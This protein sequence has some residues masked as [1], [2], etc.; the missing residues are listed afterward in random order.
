[1]TRTPL[2]KRSSITCLRA[3]IPAGPFWKNLRAA[4]LVAAPLLVLALTLAGC[5]APP[6]EAPAPEPG[7]AAMPEPEP[8]L[9][10]PLTET[11]PIIAVERRTYALD[12]VWISNELEG[13]RVSDAY[14]SGD[15]LVVVEIDPENAPI[16][17]SAWY[18]FKAW[19]Q[20]PRTVDLRL[21]YEDGDHR[22]WPK[23]RR[24]GEPWL[25]MDSARVTRDTVAGTATL[26]LSL[27]RDTLW[28]AGQEMLTSTFFDGWTDSLAA[29]P[30]ITRRT[31]ATTPEGRPIWM[32]EMGDTASTRHVV[33]ISRQH[34]PEVSGTWG[35]LAFVE[36]LAADT[37][38][39]HRFRDAFRVHI[40][41]LVNPDGVDL[42][43]W[44]HNTG[45]VDLNRDWGAFFQPET[46][47]VAEEIRRLL[48]GPDHD[49]WFAFDFH[50]TQYDVFY[51]LD[52]SLVTD[53]PG[54]TDRWLG[55]IDNALTTYDVN[56]SPSGLGL[57]TSRNWFYA[58]FGAPALIYEVGD[59]TPRPLIR[60][61]A[62][63]AAEGTMRILLDARK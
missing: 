5:G 60:Q 56:D 35:L 62:E 51:T 20:T 10:R 36:T 8:E 37:E 29:L 31:I 26:T 53:P 63:T 28:V 46:R 43:H 54:L 55:Y 2:S 52:R 49:L 16:N 13:G 4:G 18:A 7:P 61:V 40:V 44:R 39:A 34:P 23:T 58:E 42:G 21:S 30:W 48:T 3:A 24:A 15:T 25:P 19:S 57:S 1:M 47:A 33:I 38:L 22:Y 59:E 6:P 9:E 12:G 11:R 14:R 27:S 32:V 17:N 45:G 50:S 41:P